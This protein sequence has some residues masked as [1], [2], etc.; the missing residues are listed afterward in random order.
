MEENKQIRIPLRE[1]YRNGDLLRGRDVNKITHRVNELTGD[2]DKIDIDLSGKLDT[3]AY[4]EDKAAIE[5]RIDG[6]AEG[7]STKEDISAHTA[8]MEAIRAS[9]DNKVEVSAYTENNTRLDGRINSVVKLVI[10]QCNGIVAHTV[11]S[12]YLHPSMIEIEVG[13]ALTEITCIHENEVRVGCPLLLDDTQS[14]RIA[15][16]IAITLARS[17]RLDLR[18]CIIRVE[19][20]EGICLWSTSHQQKA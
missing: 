16:M 13:C 5:S 18:M 11:H 7:L 10:A 4:T 1:D 6:V 19:D 3:S 2:I 14:A 20:S 8:D 12:I 15:R 17:N 9:L